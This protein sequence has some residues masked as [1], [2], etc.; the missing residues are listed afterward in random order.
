DIPDK[1]AGISLPP[2]VQRNIG[3]IPERAAKPKVL[4]P[5]YL[6]E[7]S[8]CPRRYYYAHICRMP[9]AGEVRAQ[10]PSGSNAEAALDIAPQQLGIAFHRFLELLQGREAWRESLM[11]ALQETLPPEL[12][13]QAEGVM[14]EWA[15]R[16]ADSSLF[17]EVCSIKEDRREWG[18]QYRLLQQQGLLPTLWLSGQVDRVLFYPDGTLGILDY[19]TDHMD[20][21]SVQ[22]KIARYRLQLTGYALAAR[23]MFGKKV[24]DVRLYFVRTGEAVPVEAG[25]EALASAEKELRAIAEFIR[26]HREE[27]D[28]ACECSHCPY[29][30]FQAI[31][32][33]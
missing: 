4:S 1:K 13:R 8:S 23:A 22:K 31:C 9:A 21:P 29:C 2:E 28:Y 3:E 19:K 20:E 15:S 27:T 30:P 17:A 16:Y 26:S 10:K 14:G 6:T 24:R 11:Q 7:Y 33:Q 18:F 25:L 5:A 12:C 32:L